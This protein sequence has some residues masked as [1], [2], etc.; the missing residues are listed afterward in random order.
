[1]DLIRQKKQNITSLYMV[2]LDVKHLRNHCISFQNK[3]FTLANTPA[4]SAFPNGSSLNGSSISHTVKL[5]VYKFLFTLPG[6][7][8]QLNL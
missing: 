8:I 2:E 3:R 5:H 4:T 1:M 6:V 7:K